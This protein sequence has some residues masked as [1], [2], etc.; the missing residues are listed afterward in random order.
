[1]KHWIAF[2]LM[3]N[4]FL[5]GGWTQTLTGFIK[6]DNTDQPI[7]DVE[8]VIPN[9]SSSR[10]ASNGQF[11]INLK[12]CKS[13]QL[14]TKLG[15]F[16]FHKDYGVDYVEY[17]IEKSYTVP[18]IKLDNYYSVQI[19]GRVFSDFDRS[20]LQDIRV[21]CQLNVPGLVEPVIVTDEFG[22]FKFFFSKRA[23]GKINFVDLIFRDPSGCFEDQVISKPIR[24]LLDIDVNMRK[25]ALKSCCVPINQ[26][27]IERKVVNIIQCD[28][29]HNYHSSILRATIEGCSKNGKI[30]KIWGSFT[31]KLVWEYGGTFKI[32]Y[33]P[34]RNLITKIVAGN[35]VQNERD[36][37]NNGCLSKQ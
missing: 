31:G 25:N 5:V 18:I 8:I 17:T 20:F 1:M 10:T 3:F 24:Q 33:D 29:D 11:N 2:F 14:N 22:K 37:S 15:M 27:E 12:S 34:V 28:A 7:E 32:E 19:V 16:L 13:C 21:T 4:I 9:V 30:I 35:P 36:I 26:Y 23:V 6:D